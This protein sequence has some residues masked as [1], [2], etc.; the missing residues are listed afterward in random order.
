[1]LS[2]DKARELS[3]LILV[4]VKYR[5]IRIHG[6][7][8]RITRGDPHTRKPEKCFALVTT[9]EPAGRQKCRFTDLVHC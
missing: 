5:V 1:M 8:W 2:R 6:V 7:V 4:N 3:R 9:P